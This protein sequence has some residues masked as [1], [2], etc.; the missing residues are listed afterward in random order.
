MTDIWVQ[1][2][3]MVRYFIRTKGSLSYLANG[4]ISKPPIRC[5]HMVVDEVRDTLHVAS[6]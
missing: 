2:E 1:P 3:R 6:T 4:K 5:G